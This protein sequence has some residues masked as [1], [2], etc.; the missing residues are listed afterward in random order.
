MAFLR[1]MRDRMLG[2]VKCSRITVN[3]AGDTNLKEAGHSLDDRTLPPHLAM[4]V[5]FTRALARSCEPDL[6]D[7]DG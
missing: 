4:I 7:I 2:A 6:P 3:A 5:C 1:L